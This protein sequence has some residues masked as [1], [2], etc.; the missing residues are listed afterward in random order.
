MFEGSITGMGFADGHRVVVGRWERSPLGAF[1]DVM[2]AR[3]DGS[4]VLIAPDERVAGFV[5]SHYT[6]DEVRVSPVTAQLTATNL[7]VLAG[8]VE[9]DASIGR[10]GA[11]SLV[12]RARPRVLASSAVWGRMEALL[13][14]PLARPLM[15]GAGV[16]TA[17]RTRAGALERY[18]A[19]DLR[20]LIDAHASVGGHTCG[21]LVPLRPCGFGFSEFGARPAHVTLTAVF[22][23]TAALAPS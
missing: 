3:P 14:R 15:G 19:S 10:S 8:D 16:R 22:D 11:A 6:F 17:G 23:D 20:P 18:V 1:A 21:A 5:A 2:V 9:V 7:G 12:L 4:R 13:A